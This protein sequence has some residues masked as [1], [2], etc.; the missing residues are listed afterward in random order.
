[1]ILGTQA[2]DEASGVGMNKKKLPKV[3]ISLNDEAHPAT[4]P[5]IPSAAG[6]QSSAA[7]DDGVA[8]QTTSSACAAQDNVVRPFT[9]GSRSPDGRRRRL[10]RR[11]DSSTAD[12]GVC[13]RRPLCRLLGHRPD[14]AIGA[15][16]VSW[17][18]RRS[19][20]M[21]EVLCNHYG[22]HRSGRVPR[23]RHGHRL[24]RGRHAGRG[25][26]NYHI[27]SALHRATDCSFRS[28]G[29]QRD[30]RGVYPQRWARVHRAFRGRSIF[31][32]L[33]LLPTRPTGVAYGRNR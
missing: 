30:C 23:P 6:Q 24:G 4:S 3:I 26:G 20:A 10:A 28:C 29:L 17:D 1:M 18:Y 22:V 31:G 9:G 2:R 13:H 14:G 15:L 12:P 27:H 33:L 25:G 11:R 21:V 16:S 8:D 32:R 7:G 5:G 19:Y